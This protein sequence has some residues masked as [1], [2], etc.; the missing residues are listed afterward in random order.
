MSKLV[1]ARTY[2]WS[3]DTAPQRQEAVAMQMLVVRSFLRYIS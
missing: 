1:P 3:I 2:N